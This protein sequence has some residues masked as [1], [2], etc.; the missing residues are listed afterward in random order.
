MHVAIWPVLHISMPISGATNP[1]V[2]E[3]SISGQQNVND[4]LLT[5]V[6]MA[7]W[8]LLMRLNGRGNKQSGFI[9][10]YHAEYFMGGWGLSTPTETSVI[11]E[12]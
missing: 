5:A 10:M 6:I 1:T 7:G 9:L 12:S 3:S 4:A 11:S 2:P 8:S